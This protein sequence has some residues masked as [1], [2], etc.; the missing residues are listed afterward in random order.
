[1]LRILSEKRNERKLGKFSQ[2]KKA[3]TSSQLEY[4]RHKQKS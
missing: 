4:A 3:I 1:M 2:P